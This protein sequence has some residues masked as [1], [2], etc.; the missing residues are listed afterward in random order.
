M[1]SAKLKANREYR[2]SLN[3]FSISYAKSVNDVPITESS[4]KTL[5]DYHFR[6]GPTA[7]KDVEVGVLTGDL[8]ELNEMVKD[9]RLTRISPEEIIMA[10]FAAAHA[11]IEAAP[12][13]LAKWKDAMLN[14]T[15]VTFRL[16]DSEEGMW[17]LASHFRETVTTNQ[18]ALSR[19]PFQRIHEVT[20]FKA[21]IEK[22]QKTKLNPQEIA[23][24]FNSKVTLAADSEAVNKTFVAM[25][26]TIHKRAFNM[27]EVVAVIRLMDERRGKGVFNQITKLNAVIEKATWTKWD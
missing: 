12:D 15:D 25:A 9:C 7:I 21:R 8:P 23:D 18:A 22:A 13:T 16:V 5:Q 3:L 10:F 19:T 14:N 1:A 11:A 4:I 24:A 2:C 27:P 26:D 6:N 20:A 17:S